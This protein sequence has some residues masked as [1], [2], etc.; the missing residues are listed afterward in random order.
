[1]T[2]WLSSISISRPSPLDIEMAVIAGIRVEIGFR[3]FH[4]HLAQES[5]RP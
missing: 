5:R 3:P 1:M 2:I 4:R